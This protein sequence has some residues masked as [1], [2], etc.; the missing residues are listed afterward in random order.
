MNTIKR[1]TGKAIL[2]GTIT[3]KSECSFS[4]CGIGYRKLDV[5]PQEKFDVQDNLERLYI[6]QDGLPVYYLDARK[7]LLV[8]SELNAQGKF[9]TILQTF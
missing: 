2:Q 8:K 7:A 9:N 1:L 3:L 6:L 5:I 4:V